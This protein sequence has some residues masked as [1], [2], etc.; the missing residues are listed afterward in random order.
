MAGGGNSPVVAVKLSG[1]TQAESWSEGKLLGGDVVLQVSD[2]YSRD[3]LQMSLLDQTLFD[4]NAHDF[5]GR[6]SCE[7]M[8]LINQQ[9]LGLASDSEMAGVIESLQTNLVFPVFN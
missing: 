1:S 4:W 8:N 2:W 7:C 3:H 5:N 9:P 6:L